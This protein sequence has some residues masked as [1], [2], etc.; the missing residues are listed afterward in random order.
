MVTLREIEN[1]I[2]ALTRDDLI[3]LRD[4]FE[5]FD[6]ELWDRQ[7]EEDVKSGKLKMTSDKAVFEFKQGRYKTI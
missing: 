5:E 1:A 2:T 7:L 6:A 3:K 4:W